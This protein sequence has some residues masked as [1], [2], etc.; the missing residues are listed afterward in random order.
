MLDY[1][2]E[3]I[4]DTRASHPMNHQDLDLIRV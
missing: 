2:F 1:E 3:V 4:H